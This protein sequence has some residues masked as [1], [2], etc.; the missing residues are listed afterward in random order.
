[1]NGK[2]SDRLE[3]LVASNVFNELNAGL[4]ADRL[5]PRENAPNKNAKDC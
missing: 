5:Q 2:Y 1:M 4:K 3:N